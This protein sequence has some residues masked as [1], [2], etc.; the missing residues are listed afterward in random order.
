MAALAAA[1]HLPASAACP[2]S[3]DPLVWDSATLG[4]AGGDTLTVDCTDLVLED[5]LFDEYDTVTGPEETAIDA[6][7]ADSG[8]AVCVC[9]TLSGALHTGD[10]ASAGQN[11]AIGTVTLEHFF[12][13]FSLS[14]DV[15]TNTLNS[16][17]STDLDQSWGATTKCAELPAAVTDWADYSVTVNSQVNVTCLDLFE[18]DGPSSATTTT[19]ANPTVFWEL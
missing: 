3:F 18:V 14:S 10:T 17:A 9:Y 5:S 16:S 12:D 2:A 1:H 7:L 11:Q 13:G 19:G 4:P 15:N 8:R 6:A